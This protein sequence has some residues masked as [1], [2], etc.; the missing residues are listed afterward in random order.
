MNVIVPE[1]AILETPVC[2]V[3]AVDMDAPNTDNS[4]VQYEL[5]GEN[6]GEC[7]AFTSTLVVPL[8]PCPLR[9]T[10]CLSVEPC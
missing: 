10:D 4:D 7:P 8:H 3:L 6:K 9:S 5:I 1:N 2:R